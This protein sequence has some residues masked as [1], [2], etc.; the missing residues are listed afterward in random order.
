[1]RWLLLA[2]LLQLAPAPYGWSYED[3]VDTLNDPW[4]PCERSSTDPY[5]T[6]EVV[7]RGFCRLSCT[8]RWS[9]APER[10]DCAMLPQEALLSRA[11]SRGLERF[12]QMS[13]D[14]FSSV[15]SGVSKEGAIE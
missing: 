8:A 4:T 2:A 7:T 6:L 10:M 12:Q 1:M 9:F 15:N 14:S 3:E 13:Q 5:T 11:H